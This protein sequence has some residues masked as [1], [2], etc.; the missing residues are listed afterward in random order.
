MLRD[1]YDD[2]GCME[3]LIKGSGLEWTIIRAPMLTD[4]PRTGRYQVARN[5]HLSRG[6]SIARADLAD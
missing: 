6:A 5:K 2:M 1:A 4:K 3:A